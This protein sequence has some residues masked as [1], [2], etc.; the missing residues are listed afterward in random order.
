[1][2]WIHLLGCII[3]LIIIATCVFGNSIII[4]AIAK[5]KKFRTPYHIYLL[6]ISIS[7]IMLMILTTGFLG[8]HISEKGYI[9][10]SVVCKLGMDLY[11]TQFYHSL[12]SL[13]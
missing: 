7:D 9:F 11:I 8:E 10:G 6:N 12:F 3:N 2:K 1:M 4:V 13:F 5:C